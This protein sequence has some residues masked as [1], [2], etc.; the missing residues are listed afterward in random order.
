MT[1]ALSRAQA[2]RVFAV[3]VSE[4]GTPSEIAD[5]LGLSQVSDE[6]ALR[7]VLEALVVSHPDEVERWKTGDDAARKKLNGFFMGQAMRELKGQ[8]N[9]NV[10]TALLGDLLSE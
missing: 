9:P 2:K 5:Q 3:C 6:S 7:S 1:D 8:G 4:G 10:L